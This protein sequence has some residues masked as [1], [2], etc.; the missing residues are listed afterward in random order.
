MPNNPVQIILNSDD[1]RRPPEKSAGGPRKDFFD[2]SSQDFV[3][4]KL[5]LL[6]YVEKVRN[7]LVESRFGPATYL[8]V[9]MR[10]EGLAKSYRPI[11][12][13]FTPDRYPCVGAGAIGT[14]FFR[15]SLS[16]ID[17][18]IGR[19]DR[20]ENN[21]SA[22][23]L[24]STGKEY[25]NPS[26]E[27]S[28]VGAVESFSLISS[29]EKRR[30]STSEAL[31]IFQDKRTVSGYQIELFEYPD[32]KYGPKDLSGI[33][34]LYKSLETLLLSFGAG[35][36]TYLFSNSSNSQ[37][38]ELQLTTDSAQAIVENPNSPI[39]QNVETIDRLANVDLSIERH[40]RVMNLLQAHPLV[41]EIRLPIRLQ[42]SE[43]NE[44]FNNQVSLTN[45]KELRVPDPNP[46]QVYPVVGIIDS[47]VARPLDSWIVNRYDYLDSADY[48]SEHGTL[49]AALAAV[50]RAVN[51]VSV[52]PE[53]HG[54]QIYDI[55]LFPSGNFTNI[56][57]SGFN[58]FLDE[59]ELAVQEAV[60][61]SKVRIFNL[62]IN[63]R[64]A[65]E[66]YRYSKFAVK[67]D[68]I[69]DAYD[70]IIVNS[71]GNLDIDEFRSQWQNNSDMMI[72]YFATRT[73][74][75]AIYMPSES[76]RSVSVGALNPPGT[77]QIF[78]AP[79]VYTRR[80]PGLQVGVKPDVATFGGAG[81]TDQSA[82]SGLYSITKRGNKVDV[83]GTSFAAPI[84]ARKLADLDTNT[85]GRLNVETLK[86][87]LIHHCFLPEF[88]RSSKMRSLGRQFSGFGKPIST[89]RMFETADHQITMV[90][91][92]TLILDG[93][94]PVILRFP[95]EWPQC[96]NSNGACS[97]KVRMTLVYSPPINPKWGTEFVRV[98]LDAK[99]SQQQIETRKD[100]QPRFKNQIQ[101][102]VSKY[103]LGLGSNES[104]LIR[105]G[106]KWW[107]CKQYETNFRSK[108]TST[109][110]KLEVSSITRAESKF[111]SKGIPFSVILTIEDY[112]EV[113]P[114]FRDMQK[115]LQNRGA[116][117]LPIQAI[118]R[119]RQ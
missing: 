8:K 9:Q 58:G 106:L 112:D 43:V 21:V 117:T 110:W 32:Q 59:V 6:N 31:R 48:N 67:V 97:G 44:K 96:L 85:N 24:R 39:A 20:A 105:H 109:Q 104:A 73:L 42:L 50:P 75:D 116:I 107:P 89:Q 87:M 35:S 83:A 27:R 4:H 82:N 47:G 91:E 76:I 18:L 103:K 40:E 81:S 63:N 65:V 29:D 30:F 102:N 46:R 15:I 16:Q 19:I 98:N 53:D 114:V 95:F 11:K 72:E 45:Q 34:A 7:H 93:D 118:N 55:P 79:T 49:V 99:L 100:G 78:E 25:K 51:D 26:I 92:S 64:S 2:Y 69:S 36:R 101:S 33:S 37:E 77:D 1:F 22:K 68:E 108:G 71:V 5:S 28:E 60:N 62:S 41:R 111:P 113:K 88:L 84:I 90:F 80:G 23:K 115:I 17:E 38:L 54:C 52:I 61:K 70:V 13:I 94:K 74:S 3:K 56:Y 66:Y 119:F 86:A 57:R 14:L 10:E 12:R